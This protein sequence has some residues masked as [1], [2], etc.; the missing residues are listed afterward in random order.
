MYAIR[1]YYELGVDGE[2][3]RRAEVSFRVD[4]AAMAGAGEI[5]VVVQ[6][7]NSLWRIARRIYGEGMAYTE[8]F[9]AT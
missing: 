6:P 8:I 1:S 4:H 3:V 2:V 7:G 9:E 5:I